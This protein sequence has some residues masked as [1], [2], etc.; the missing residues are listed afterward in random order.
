MLLDR[1]VLDSINT[2]Q[3]GP[4]KRAQAEPQWLSAR[5]NGTIPAGLFQLYEQMAY[6]SFGSAPKILHDERNVVFSYFSMLLNCLLENL[7]DAAEAR[8]ALLV[9]HELLYD[10]GKKLRGRTWDADADR[11]FR[12]NLRNILIAL[13]GTLDTLA[14]LI[15]LILTGRWKISKLVLGKGDFK[16]IE[17]WLKT[18]L[19][20]PSSM[21]SPYDAK[22]RQLHV[23]LCPLVICAAPEEDW[24]GL[25]HVLRNKILHFGQSMLR[26][27]GLHDQNFDFFVFIPKQWPFIYEAE[28][29]S[30][31]EGLREDSVPIADKFRTSLIHQDVPEFLKGL[32]N[33]VFDVTAVIVRWTAS[34]CSEFSKHEVT[35]ECVKAL[36]LPLAQSSFQYFE[37]RT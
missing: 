10:P 9:D 11:R 26:M 17:A 14:D 27:V 21:V 12:R 22:V 34:M 30:R 20:A 2:T 3:T 19:T 16:A 18:P 7:L 8:E 29:R 24:L 6:L 31:G 1:C 23:D 4:L 15:A 13:D 32:H 25:T 5:D 28:I 35:R 33:R 37:T 36:H